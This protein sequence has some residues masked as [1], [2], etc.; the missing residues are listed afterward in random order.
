MTITPLH[1]FNGL[2][3]AELVRIRARTRRDHPFLIWEPFEGA[4]ETITYGQQAE[5]IDPGLFN[6]EVE[7]WRRARVVGGANGKNPVSIIVPCHRVI[8]ANGS[9]TGYGGGM[10]RKKLLLDLEQGDPLIR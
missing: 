6:T 10:E 3:V 7:P 8:G 2:D 5:R 1:P 9:L 4:G